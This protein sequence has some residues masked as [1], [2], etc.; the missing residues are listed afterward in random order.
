M[1]PTDDTPDT[2]ADAFDQRIEADAIAALAQL[3]LDRHRATS[4]GDRITADDY[5][6][7]GQA[8]LARNYLLAQLRDAD[9]EA[10]EVNVAGEA[11]TP[12]TDP[13][14]TP[15]FE[16]T[17]ASAHA[18]ASAVLEATGLDIGRNAERVVSTVLGAAL[19]GLERPWRAEL[20]AARYAAAVNAQRATELE[21]QRDR[22]RE[23][24]DANK[25]LA[26]YLHQRLDTTLAVTQ[27][28][29]Q[30]IDDVERLLDEYEDGD[31]D[32]DVIND[33]INEVLSK[34]REE[35]DR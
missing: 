14:D 15:S 27:R 12:T 18:A 31:G 32:H 9:T 8:V 30:V 10:D 28:R 25:H 24:R 22:S 13:T 34:L 6:L 5:T 3:Q 4:M 29:G 35:L 7:E 2:E 23:Q 21:W 17:Y 26:E 33:V 11:R 16:E 1:N 19:L 20:E